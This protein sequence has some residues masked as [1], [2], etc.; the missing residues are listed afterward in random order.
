MLHAGILMMLT[1]WQWT[2][3]TQCSEADC[4]TVWIRY[5]MKLVMSSEISAPASKLVLWRR[6]SAISRCVVMACRQY[7]DVHVVNEWAGREQEIGFSLPGCQMCFG[8]VDRH[9]S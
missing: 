2:L 8:S 9:D 1:A 4:L 3:Q 7:A 6:R 5:G